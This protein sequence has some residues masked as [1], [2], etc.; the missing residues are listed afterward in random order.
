MV[1]EV[2]YPAIP[3]D[4]YHSP[5][6]PNIPASHLPPTAM[7][8]WRPA[9]LMDLSIFVNEDEY[10]TAYQSKPVLFAEDI[11]LG[12]ASDSREYRLEIPTTQVPVSYQSG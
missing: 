5:Y 3:N 7:P 10:F 4:V 2:T 1:A 11:V 12:D 8:L 6:P 9:T